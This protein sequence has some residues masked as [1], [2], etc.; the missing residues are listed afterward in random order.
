MPD[1]KCFPYTRHGSWWYGAFRLNENGDTQCGSRDGQNCL[2][3]QSLSACS[4]SPP[5]SLACGAQYKSINGMTGYGDPNHWCDIM[6]AQLKT[7]QTSSRTTE[8]PATSLPVI[9]HFVPSYTPEIAGTV[10]I[11]VLTMSKVELYP[12][13]FPAPVPSKSGTTVK[14][15]C[16]KYHV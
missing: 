8:T 5:S 2:W 6:R 13:P 4:T 14:E 3:V 16:F 15:P 11:P 9:K 12:T 10:P 7:Q 1:W